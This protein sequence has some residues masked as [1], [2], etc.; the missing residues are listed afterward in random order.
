VVTLSTFCS[1]F[2]IHCICREWCH[3]RSTW[4]SIWKLDRSVILLCGSLGLA[5]HVQWR[6]SPFG[7]CLKSSAATAKGVYGWSSVRIERTPVALSQV[8]AGMY[9]EV[10][11]KSVELPSKY[12]GPFVFGPRLPYKWLLINNKLTCKFSYHSLLFSI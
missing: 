3:E 11:Q 2:L 4:N 8:G 9:G 10:A 1:A 12:P 5:V 7:K 6:M